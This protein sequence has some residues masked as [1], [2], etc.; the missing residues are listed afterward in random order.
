MNTYKMGD[1]QP[2]DFFG[3]TDVF[4]KPYEADLAI[5]FC[6]DQGNI[7]QSVRNCDVKEWGLS[8][9]EL[10]EIAKSNLLKQKPF[11]EKFYDGVY[12][13]TLS[14]T[15]DS[16]LMLL[17]DEILQLDLLGDPVVFL[18]TRD[19]LLVTGKNDE[20][21]FRCVMDELLNKYEHVIATSPYTL[22]N[23]KWQPFS[24]NDASEIT[25]KYLNFDH[26]LKATNTNEFL[27]NLKTL[28]LDDASDNFYIYRVG[29]GHKD[30]HDFT[31]APW[32]E[33]VEK[34]WIPKVDRITV[35]TW[36]SRMA[37]EEQRAAM[38]DE[39]I[40]DWKV[41][42]QVCGSNIKQLDFFHEIWEFQGFPTDAEIEKMKMLQNQ[43]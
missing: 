9:D 30:N 32:L 40:F 7:V 8:F 16:A 18:G 43:K 36:E 34:N 11:F 21:G 29:L 3:K 26:H 2:K 12:I 24:I 31:Y 17:K 13:S 15:C 41:V 33:G 22:A 38:R 37:N 5:G 25:R 4:Y 28:Y 39:L 10:L 35:A 1:T 42:T 27:E 14:N 20:A 23:G 6:L 19:S